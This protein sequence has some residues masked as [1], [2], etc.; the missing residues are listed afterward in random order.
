MQFQVAID[1]SSEP[2]VFELTD[3]AADTSCPGSS[4]IRLKVLCRV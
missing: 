1:E 2:P 4:G 3:F